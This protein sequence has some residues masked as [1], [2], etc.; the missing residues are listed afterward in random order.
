[1][2][3]IYHHLGL[4]DHIICNGLVRTIIDP[5]ENYTLFC[6]PQY[7]ESVSFMYRDLK[8]L[9]VCAKDDKDVWNFIITN[10]LLNDTIKIG[11]ENL[12]EGNKQFDKKFYEQLNIDFNKRWESFYILRDKDR[13]MELFKKYDV[14]ENNYV[15]IHEDKA[16]NYVI[17]RDYII[18]RHLKLIEPNLIL[19]SNIFDYIYLLKNAKEIH[20]IDSSFR[21]IVDTLKLNTTLLFAHDYT[22]ITSIY[23]PSLAQNWKRLTQYYQSKLKVYPNT[24]ELNL[25]NYIEPYI[26]YWGQ[27]KRLTEVQGCPD[28]ARY[29]ELIC[30]GKK[31]VDL[32]NEKN[33]DYVFLPYM[34]KNRDEYVEKLIKIAKDNG[35]K[36]VVFFESDSTEY[37]DIKEDEGYIFRTSFYKSKQRHNERALPAWS[38]DF[39]KSLEYLN[40]RPKSEIPIASFCGY[41]NSYEKQGAAVNLAQSNK[42]KMIL[43]TR[44]N[45]HGHVELAQRI[46]NRYEFVDI[47]KNSDYVVCARGG[48]NFSYRFYET[49][50]FGKI[51]IFVNSDC[52]LPFDNI[53]DYKDF[54]VW[55]ENKDIKNIDNILVEYHSKFTNTSF[56]EH[57]IKCRN[58]WE[59]YLSATGF[60]KHIKDAINE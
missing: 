33:S 53:I 45:F 38:T 25:V 9:T 48:G 7:Y 44:E 31:Y 3:Y 12:V 4:G 37:V 28:N 36:I 52:V 29:E 55:I 41:I 23:P 51:P 22:R 43:K 47:M 39:V 32:V 42:V 27:P 6:K 26:P 20:C 40:P 58:F 59:E 8:N 1:M 15:F 35:K 13:E 17:N 18:N 60:L 54:C 5:K 49:L 16:R 19:T 34:W 24:N 10:N 2:K 46:Q 14:K 11:F 50:A 30:D 57:Q 21:L 56:I